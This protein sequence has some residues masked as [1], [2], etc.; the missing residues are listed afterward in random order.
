ML[1]AS[2]DHS[3]KL[4]NIN[5]SFG[6]DYNDEMFNETCLVSSINHPSF[7]YAARFYPEPYKG[8]RFIIITACFDGKVR[9]F[10]I[11]I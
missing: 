4:W 1:T 9:I 6:D 10:Y 5:K 8:E 2:S 11:E 3:A 7:V